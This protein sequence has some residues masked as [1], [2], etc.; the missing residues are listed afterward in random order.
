MSRLS[1]DLVFRRMYRW[2]VGRFFGDPKVGEEYLPLLYQQFVASPTTH[3]AFFGLN[4]D[5]PATIAAGTAAVP[6][7]RRFARPVRVN[8]GAADPYLTAR[9]AR[10]F[11]QLLPTSE[12]FLLPDAPPLR[13]DGPTRSGRP[14]APYNPQR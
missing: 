14:A 2:Q 3:E 13:A 5:L 4:R 7:L 6:R 12:L 8:F 9:V 11:H 10:R 1:G